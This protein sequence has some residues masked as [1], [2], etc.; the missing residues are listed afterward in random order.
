MISSTSG[1]R[2]S[3]CFEKTSFPSA[4]TSNWLFAPSTISAS[5]SV[6]FVSAAARLAA[7]RS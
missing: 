1:K 5:C 4:S 2:P 7:R 3:F 6:R